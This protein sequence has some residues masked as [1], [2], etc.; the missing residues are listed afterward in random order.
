MGGGKFIPIFI[1]FALHSVCPIER[2]L[3]YRVGVSQTM[4]KTQGSK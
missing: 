2:V 1:N 4:I 3:K